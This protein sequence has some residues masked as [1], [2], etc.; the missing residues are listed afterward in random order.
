MSEKE[1]TS[2]ALEM[3]DRQLKALDA[4]VRWS[5]ASGDVRVG[6]ERLNTWETR[7]IRLVSEHVNPEEGN[8][9][10][11]PHPHDLS[12]GPL[13]AGA[14]FSERQLM[15]H[16]TDHSSEYARILTAIK[17]ELEERPEETLNAG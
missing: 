14:V 3:I 13:E 16:L 15:R 4:T 6:W 11:I 10:K 2:A 17:A 12:R 1:K 5:R 7:T 9:L 8:K